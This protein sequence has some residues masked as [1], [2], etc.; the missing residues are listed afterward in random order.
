[1]NPAKYP[2]IS[3][4]VHYRNYY[5]HSQVQFNIYYQQNSYIQEAKI[6]CFFPIYLWQILK[7]IWRPRKSEDHIF[8][9][10]EFRRSYEESVNKFS[11]VRETDYKQYPDFLLV[12]FDDTEVIWQADIPYYTL[13]KQWPNPKDTLWLYRTPELQNMWSYCTGHN[14]Y[15][16]HLIFPTL[17]HYSSEELRSPQY[18]S[19]KHPYINITQIIWFILPPKIYIINLAT[20]TQSSPWDVAIIPE[21]PQIYLRHQNISSAPTCNTP[22]PPPPPP[23]P[24]KWCWNTRY[25][26]HHWS[27]WWLGADRA[28]SHYLSQCC[29]RICRNMMSLARNKQTPQCLSPSSFTWSRWLPELPHVFSQSHRARAQSCALYPL[30]TSPR[31]H[32]LTARRLLRYTIELVGQGCT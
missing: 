16:K 1:M 4:A 21:E 14:I 28:T 24:P 30:C 32:Q 20:G 25:G 31:T 29:P 9:L 22:P 15:R 18:K 26:S 11:R 5:R 7:K 17:T 3:S 23:P 19:L 2:E 27:R 6:W 10:Q 12:S 8:G 13:Q